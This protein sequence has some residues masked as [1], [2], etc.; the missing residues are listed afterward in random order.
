MLSRRMAWMV[1][2]MATLTMT[3][4]YFDRNAMGVLAPEMT[5][6]LGISN[7]AYGWVGSAFSMA[8]LLG[9]PVAGWWIGIIGARRGLLASV[10]TWSVVAALHAVMPGFAVLFALRLA[11][12]LAEGP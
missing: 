5:K 8:Y 4:S 12:G 3:V 2:L 6:A 1:A 7:T 10:L 11:L 9:T